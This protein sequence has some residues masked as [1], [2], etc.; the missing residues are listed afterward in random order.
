VLKGKIPFESVFDM[1]VNNSV[2]HTL[3]YYCGCLLELT[4]VGIG[5]LYVPPGLMLRN[6]TL[7]PQ[8]LFTCFMDICSNSDYS[9][10]NIN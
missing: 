5:F 8:S 1:T 10:Q 4:L 2:L 7:Y 6:S 3:S 9:L